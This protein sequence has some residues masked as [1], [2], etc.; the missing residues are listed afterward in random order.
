MATVELFYIISE[1]KFNVLQKCKSEKDNA[2]VSVHS[3]HDTHDNGNKQQHPSSVETSSTVSGIPS[4]EDSERSHDSSDPS[5]DAEHTEEEIVTDPMSSSDILQR[6]NGGVRRQ[7]ASIL[8]MLKP[9]LQ[10]DHNGAIITRVG[11]VIH[12]SN[13]TTIL[14]N[15]VQPYKKRHVI[16]SH[17]VDNIINRMN[18]PIH[19]MAKET[20]T[21]DKMKKPKSSNHDKSVVQKPIKW[22]RF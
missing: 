17:Y 15:L 20:M 11:D 7:A 16:G 13:M 6:L 3:N 21:T 14:R 8:H 1:D 2:E 12:G 19:T 22:L 10:W 9:S 5:R 4:S 18:L